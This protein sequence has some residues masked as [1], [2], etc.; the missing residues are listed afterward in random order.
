MFQA[1]TALLV[2]NR[3]AYKLLLLVVVPSPCTARWFV[4]LLQLVWDLILLVEVVLIK[5]VQSDI[6]EDATDD[7]GQDRTRQDGGGEGVLEDSR[8]I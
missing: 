8:D 4:P 5:E 3:N 2:K 6:P 7:K 1:N